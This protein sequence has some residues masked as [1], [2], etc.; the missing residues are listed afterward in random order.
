MDKFLKGEEVYGDNFNIEEIRAWYKDEE[1][2]YFSI[3]G[4]NNIGKSGG[5]ENEIH[6]FY[7]YNIIKNM[8][9]K[10]AMGLG[11]AD[12]REFLPI[13][14][15]IDKL[16]IIEIAEE[17]Y[18]NDIMGTPVEYVKPDI[19]GKLSYSDNYFDLIFVSS[20]LHHI[21]NLSFVWGEIT[22]CLAPGGIL[23][24]SEPIVYMGGFEGKRG[25]LTLRERGIP[26]K[27][28]NERLSDFNIILKEQFNHAITRKIISKFMKK[29]IEDSKL[30]LKIDRILSRNFTLKYKYFAKN[31]ISKLFRA[32]S[33]YMVLEKK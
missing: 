17:F 28:F 21:P 31:P 13:I 5:S 29:G 1:K 23:I 27:F 6:N 2:G 9:F 26:I 18:K 12:G 4:E 7:S 8:H 14:N 33:L 15:N 25:G 20:V 22:R 19:L 10:N 11:S 16:V 24:V 3:Y 32:A 30:L